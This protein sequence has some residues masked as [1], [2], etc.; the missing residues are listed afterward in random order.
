V[1]DP[2]FL[3]HLGTDLSQ[4]PVMEIPLGMG[5]S[6]DAVPLFEVEMALPSGSR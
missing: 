3:V 4:T 1:A 5:A 6:F 2:A